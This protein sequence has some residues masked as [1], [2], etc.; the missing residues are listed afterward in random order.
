MNRHDLTSNEIYL[1]E[2]YKVNY[3]HR[4]AMVLFVLS[5]FMSIISSVSTPF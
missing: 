5:I 3:F 4:A 2:R 1:K